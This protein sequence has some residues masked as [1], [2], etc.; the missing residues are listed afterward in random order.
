MFVHSKAW[1]QGKQIELPSLWL[2]V[3]C[4]LLALVPV[5][6][7]LFI[8]GSYVWNSMGRVPDLLDSTLA[9]LLF[10]AI[11]ALIVAVEYAASV[12][13][14]LGACSTVVAI[15]VFLGGEMLLFS[16][17]QLLAL[18][19]L[20]TFNDQNH[21]W[22]F[23]IWTFLCGYYALTIGICHFALARKIYR[24][25]EKDLDDSRCKK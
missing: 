25:Q 4:F 23:A 22:Q 21:Q 8:A 16:G 3:T 18:F 17:Y 20:I 19:G 7:L 1:I 14:N 10:S 9:F 13:L 6:W 2:R 11:A 24:N 12:R 15:A 5:G